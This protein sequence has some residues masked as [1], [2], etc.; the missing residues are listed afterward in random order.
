M[1][2]NLPPPL[3]SPPQNRAVYDIVWK[4]TVEP[5]SSQITIWRTCIVCRARKTKIALSEYV[6]LISFPLQQHLDANA[7]ECHVIRTFSI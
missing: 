7:P 6:L 1:I 3:P 5:V 2:N 4:N